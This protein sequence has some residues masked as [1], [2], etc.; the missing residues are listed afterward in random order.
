MVSL[1]DFPLINSTLLEL[2]WVSNIMTPEPLRTLFQVIFKPFAHPKV[3]VHQFAETADT[4]VVWGL[5]TSS[6]G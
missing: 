6:L 1:S 3:M 5:R 4:S 2:A